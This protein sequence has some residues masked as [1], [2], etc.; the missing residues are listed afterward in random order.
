[1]VLPSSATVHRIEKL[2]SLDDIDALI[3]DVYTKVKERFAGSPDYLIEEKASM[4]IIDTLM[5]SEH[6]AFT[7]R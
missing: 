3:Q 4:R 6:I 5:K 1:M 7:R 2:K